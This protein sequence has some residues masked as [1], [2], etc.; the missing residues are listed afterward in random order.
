MLLAD[1]IC[2]GCDGCNAFVTDVIVTCMQWLM[3]PPYLEII[4]SCIMTDGKSHIYM[5]DVVATWQMLLPYCC[6][7]MFWPCERWNHMCDSWCNVIVTDGITTWLFGWCYCHG[8]WN[9]HI[10]W[11]GLRQ[12]LLLFW[13]MLCQRVIISI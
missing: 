12:M 7:L 5:A 2:R 1:V 8:R 10:G 4:I 9:S 3:E 11:N 6:R 13:Q